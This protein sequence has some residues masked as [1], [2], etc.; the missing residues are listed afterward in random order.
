MSQLIHSLTAFS[1]VL[2]FYLI[3]G[4]CSEGQEGETKK[5]DSLKKNA[6]PETVSE[7]VAQEV[8]TTTASPATR[9]DSDSGKN[10]VLKQTNFFQVLTEFKI[11]WVEQTLTIVAKENF[12]RKME[13]L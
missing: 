3:C 1:I 9:P 5:Q 12:I 10:S 6:E 8:S 2:V 4:S 7:N 11:F 13:R